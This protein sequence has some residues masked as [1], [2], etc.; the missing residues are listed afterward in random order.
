[1]IRSPCEFTSHRT[2]FSSSTSAN[3]QA[4]SPRQGACL[5]LGVAMWFTLSMELSVGLMVCH[6]QVEVCKSSLTFVFPPFTMR[7]QWS[8]LGDCSTAWVLE[9]ENMWFRPRLKHSLA[10]SQHLTNCCWNCDMS[11]KQIFASVSLCDLEVVCYAVLL[12]TE[13]TETRRQRQISV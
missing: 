13:L 11:K 2:P 10:E 9:W 7:T 6:M 12:Q 3:I 4:H 8:S 5:I 1:M